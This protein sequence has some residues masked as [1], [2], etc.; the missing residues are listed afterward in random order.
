M[1][2]DWVGVNRLVHDG[3]VV[4]LVETTLFEPEPKEDVVLIDLMDE[5]VVDGVEDVGEGVELVI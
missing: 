2:V 1:V 4:G 5:V 3:L